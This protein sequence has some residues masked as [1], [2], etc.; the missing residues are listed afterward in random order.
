MWVGDIDRVVDEIE[1]FLTGAHLPPPPADR[2]L[3]TVLLVEVPEAD[4]LAV[5]H[6][7]AEWR[8]LLQ[9]TRG[10]IER[11]LSS[12]QPCGRPGRARI[13]AEL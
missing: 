12:A 2:S 8:E 3:A 13:F 4:R 1:A 5:R 10:L 9:R 7:D 6:G 11:G